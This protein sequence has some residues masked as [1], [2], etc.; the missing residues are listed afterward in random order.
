MRAVFVDHTGIGDI[1]FTMIRDVP[2]LDRLEGVGAFN[3]LF[4]FILWMVANAL[5]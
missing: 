3:A 1:A 4:V 5:A 2:I